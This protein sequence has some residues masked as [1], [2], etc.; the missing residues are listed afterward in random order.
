MGNLHPLMDE[1]S[2]YAQFSNFGKI[3]SIKMK[4]N[5]KTEESKGYAFIVF[6][7]FE[8]A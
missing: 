5:T 7:K 6:D 1:I 4:K 3:E 2:L 8:N